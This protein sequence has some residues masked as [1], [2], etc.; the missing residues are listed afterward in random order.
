MVQFEIQT[1]DAYIFSVELVLSILKT[2]ITSGLCTA[3]QTGK[4][5]STM[6]IPGIADYT[7]C[8]GLIQNRDNSDAIG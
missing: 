3:M 8:R 1:F 2:P 6:Q 5:A 7:V 4:L